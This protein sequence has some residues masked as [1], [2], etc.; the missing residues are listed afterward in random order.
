MHLITIKQLAFLVNILFIFSVNLFAEKIDVRKN[1]FEEINSLRTSVGIKPLLFD[2]ELSILAKK[3]SI[4]L[5]SE[6]ELSHEENNISS[7]NFI[8]KKLEDRVLK[9]GLENKY[10][11]F[12]EIITFNF[13]PLYSVSKFKEAIKHRHVLLNNSF[14]HIG[15]SIEKDKDNNFLTNIVFSS[16]EKNKDNYFYTYPYSKEQNVPLFFDSDK[17]SPDPLKEEHIVGFPYTVYFNSEYLEI[18]K[19]DINEYGKDDV[20]LN[21]IILK[22]NNKV[23]FIPFKTLK[24]NE[25]YIVNC[26]VKNKSTNKELNYTTYFKTEKFKK[27]EFEDETFNNYIKLKKNETNLV[28]IRNINQNFIRDFKLEY[29]TKDENSENVKVYFNNFDLV[30]LTGNENTEGYIYLTDKYFIEY[31]YLFKIE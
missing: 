31:K 23:S 6:K 16:N 25:E 3:H 10:K 27:I 26:N 2:E 30:F 9:L 18:L 8:G 11:Y 15:I 7:P 12:N 4:Y 19:C 1:I 17:E 24:F 21:K 22:E 28:K 13:N 20:Y 5:I 29:K 14:T